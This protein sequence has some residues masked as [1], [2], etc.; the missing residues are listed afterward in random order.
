VGR[1]ATLGIV[2]QTCPNPQRGEQRQ[3]A[4]KC[5]NLGLRSAPD[6]HR[7]HHGHHASALWQEVK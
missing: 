7:A 1:R 2:V 3:G 5:Q 4:Y 6:P